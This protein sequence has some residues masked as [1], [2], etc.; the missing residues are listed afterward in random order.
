MD[1]VNDTDP[2]G[3]AA[4]RAQSKETQCAGEG[5]DYCVFEVSPLTH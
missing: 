5:N 1:W 2:N 4:P 3:K